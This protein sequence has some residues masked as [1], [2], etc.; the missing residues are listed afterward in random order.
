M[1]ASSSGFWA[2][3]QEEYR[4][5]KSAKPAPEPGS[6]W[7][8]L[9]LVAG[10]VGGYAKRRRFSFRS[11]ALA[12]SVFRA[13]AIFFAARREDVGPADLS[14]TPSAQAALQPKEPPEW[15]KKLEKKAEAWAQKM[16]ERKQNPPEST[17]PSYLAQLAQA[18]AAGAI[19]GRLRS[20]MAF[21]KAMLCAAVGG[22]IAMRGVEWLEKPL[23]RVWDRRF[24]RSMEEGVAPTMDATTVAASDTPNVARPDTATQD[25]TVLRPTVLQSLL[26]A[27][28][29]AE[30]S[31][32]QSLT[33]SDAAPSAP[34]GTS[35][36]ATDE[37]VLTPTGASSDGDDAVEKSGGEAE[38][39]S[40]GEAV[41]ESGEEL[42]S[43][44]K[45]R[46]FDLGEKSWEEQLEELDEVE[47]GAAEAIKRL[48][49]GRQLNE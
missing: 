25:T 12:A 44:L 19:F 49:K 41:Q 8:L 37:P 7:L 10:L 24:H 5:K 48:R 36:P 21:L 45:Y 6:N 32:G 29:P 46:T 42:L 30:K 38:E 3:F 27:V 40:G 13:F 43:R 33:P 22:M 35:E 14:V 34:Q 2:D 26:A 4:R 23:S 28:Q 17:E 39:K 20:R 18:I 47:A 9:A 11:A 1:E 31:A 15:V 16:E